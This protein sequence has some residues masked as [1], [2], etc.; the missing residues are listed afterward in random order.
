M[1]D[2]LGDT[3]STKNQ[4]KT[5]SRNQVSTEI[6]RFSQRIFFYLSFYLRLNLRIAAFRLKADWSRR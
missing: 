4:S 6:Y 2:P 1:G 5:L 3:I